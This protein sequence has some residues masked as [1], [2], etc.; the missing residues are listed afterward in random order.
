MASGFLAKIWQWLSQIW[1]QPL[2]HDN[3]APGDVI[4]ETEYGI[5]YEVGSYQPGVVKCYLVRY[6]DYPMDLMINLI[7][8]SQ[9]RQDFALGQEYKRSSDPFVLVSGSKFD[10]QLEAYLDQ[11]GW[12][13]PVHISHVVAFFWRGRAPRLYKVGGVNQRG[14]SIYPVVAI[15]CDLQN[16]QPNAGDRYAIKIATNLGE[17]ALKHYEGNNQL[18][19]MVK[20]YPW[21]CAMQELAKK[22]LGP[23]HILQPIKPGQQPDN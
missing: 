12:L 23:N 5:L 15:P 20:N 17:I 8:L 16:F 11:Y 4:K 21:I 22:R 2:P 13:N 9:L 14:Y 1:Q 6:F 3:V 19:G 18:Q 10:E 7:S